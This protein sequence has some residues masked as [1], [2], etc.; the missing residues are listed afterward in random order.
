M[1]ERNADNYTLREQAA[2]YRATVAVCGLGGGG[3]W[4][5]EILARTG[6]GHVILIDGDRYEE[7]N[8]NRQLGALGST[9]GGSKVE[10]MAA[11]LRDIS[12]YARVESHAVF[13]APETGELLSKADI[14]CDC[15]DGQNKR[16]LL[17]LAAGLRKP[18][19]TGGLSGRNWHV[20]VFD[21]AARARGLYNASG[22]SLQA[23][24]A[25]LLAC[26][27]FQAQAVIDFLLERINTPLN[28]VIR[29]NG[30]TC[31][32]FVEDVHA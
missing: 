23:N 5:A 24:P 16:L 11:R 19:C 13:I 29:F 15:V 30:Y 21:D 2:L 6:I 18:Y 1:F 32:F 3:G 31:S 26:S 12:P 20:A 7:S 22:A 14:V 17:E 10:V 9:L 8:R 4:V 25:S 28:R 27:G